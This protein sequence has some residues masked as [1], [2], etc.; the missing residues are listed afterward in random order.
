[1]LAVIKRGVAILYLARAAAKHFCGFKNDATDAKLGQFY[2][3]G[4]ARITAANDGDRI[5][6]HDVTH[7][8]HAIHNLRS[9]VS[10]VR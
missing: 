4:D 8:F 1:M 7:V 3:C 5:R 6:I 2:R 9:G 10:D